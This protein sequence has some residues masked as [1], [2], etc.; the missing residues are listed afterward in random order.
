MLPL[1]GALAMWL[2]EDCIL[3]AVNI[4][5]LIWVSRLPYNHFKNS[6]DYDFI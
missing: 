2:T 6:M 3:M 4:R 5:K 1:G